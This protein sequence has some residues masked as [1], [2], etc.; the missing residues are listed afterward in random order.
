MQD[1]DLIEGKL[2][3]QHEDFLRYC[4]EAGKKF[5]GEPDREDFIA[6]RTEYSV[7]REQVEQIFIP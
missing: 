5:V 1:N 2:F 3:G 6:Y 4:K 7:T